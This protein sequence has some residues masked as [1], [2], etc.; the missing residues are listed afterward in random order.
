CI[1]AMFGAGYQVRRAL[2]CAARNK[3]RAYGAARHERTNDPAAVRDRLGLTRT[4]LEHVAYACLDEAPHLRRHLTKALAMHLAD[5]VW[6]ATERHLFRD[7]RGRR[8]GAP[9]IG[10]WF[11]FHRLPGRARSHTRPRKWETFRLHGSL[12]GH[13]AAYTDAAGDF[14]QPARLRAV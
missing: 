13:R 8:Q 6:S 3:A 11:D 4:A 12:A 10:R 7:A 14:V 2:Q 5:S 1:E 9:H